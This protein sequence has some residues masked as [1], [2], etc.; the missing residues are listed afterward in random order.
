M[1]DNELLDSFFQAARE[2][3]ISDDGFT[4]RVMNSLPDTT[5]SRRLRRWSR[6]W[7]LFCIAVAAALLLWLT[8]WSLLQAR[9][10]ALLP[11]VLVFVFTLPSHLMALLRT[12][13]GGSNV[14]NLLLLS[15]MLSWAGMSW[16]VRRAR[17]YM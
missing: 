1:T 17:L 2:T 13:I 8:D 9:W 7:T 3:T 12:A 6:L 4:E 14:W 11:D 5:A 15:V 16:A 10:Q